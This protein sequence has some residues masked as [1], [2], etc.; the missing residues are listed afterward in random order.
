MSYFFDEDQI[1]MRNIVRQFVE[2]EVKPRATEIYGGNAHGFWRDMHKRLCELGLMTAN[3]PTELGGL[4]A[5]PSTLLMIQEELSRECPALALHVMLNATVPLGMWL[6]PEAAKVWFPKIISGEAIFAAG[7]TDPVGIVNYS[8]S[9]DMAVLDGDYYVLNGTKN[10]CSG[11]PYADVFMIYGFY[12]GDM[13]GFTIGKDTPGFTIGETKKMGMGHTFGILNLK[14]V[15]VHKDWSADFSIIAKD[16]QP[17]PHAADGLTSMLNVPSMQ[18]GLAEAVLEKTVEYLKV[19][20]HSG[21]PLASRSD[22]ASQL[23]KMSVKVELLRNHIYSCAR[24]QEEGRQV[25]MYENMA[26]VAGDH[27]CVDVA[28][29]CMQLH[30]GLG[31][32]VD[33]GIERYLRDAMGLSIADNQTNMHISSIAYYMGLPGAKIGSF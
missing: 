3:M 18:L 30:G 23:V 32:C 9:E 27:V 14:N 13:R 1:L 15:R 29:Q 24:L 5:P 10:F 8:E 17:T 31:Y 26:K 16:K 2:E 6:M 33:T 19:R 11:A 22:I 4:G 12:K 20:T 21:Q 25:H 7:V 28:R